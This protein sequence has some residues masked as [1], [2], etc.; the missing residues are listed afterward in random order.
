LL[1]FFLRRIVLEVLLRRIILR[2]H[3]QDVMG[4]A[5]AIFFCKA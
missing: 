1:R 2:E 5:R 3:L 4:S